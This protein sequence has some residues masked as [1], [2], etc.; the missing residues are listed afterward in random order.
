MLLCI[1]TGF[2]GDERRVG[3]IARKKI[4]SALVRTLVVMMLA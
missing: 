3:K 1:A 4:G 2:W